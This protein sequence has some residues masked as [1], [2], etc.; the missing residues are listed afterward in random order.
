MARYL[1]NEM[2]K[3]ICNDHQILA[4]K[5]NRLLINIIR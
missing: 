4:E 3:K 1:K 5:L 2:I